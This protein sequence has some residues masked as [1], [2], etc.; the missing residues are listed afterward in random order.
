MESDTNLNIIIWCQ[1]NSRSPQRHLATVSVAA[2]YSQSTHY[3]HLGTPGD[4]PGENFDT[5]PRRPA[6]MAAELWQRLQEK[7]SKSAQQNHSAWL[8]KASMLL[9]YET[10]LL[11][12]ATWSLLLAPGQIPREPWNYYQS[13]RD[14]NSNHI[15]AELSEICKLKMSSNIGNMLT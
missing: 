7:D 1:K 9:E 13:Q 5:L 11:A 10:P 2:I 8:L 4:R 15:N 6:P 12:L 14:L 3:C